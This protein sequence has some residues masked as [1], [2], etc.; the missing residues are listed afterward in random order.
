M[1]KISTL[2]KKDL[3]DLSRVTRE[4]DEENA[5]VFESGIPT[6]K[7]DGT[8]CAIIEG[9]LY[10]RYDLKVGRQ[11]PDGAI[12]CQEADLKTGHHPHWIPVTSNDK[13]HLEAFEMLEPK[14]DGTYE[15]CGPKING[16][17]EKLTEHILIPHGLDV[18]DITDFSF[19][20]L[21]MYLSDSSN[22]IEGIVFHDSNGSGRMCKIR[23][24]DFG[25]ER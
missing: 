3:T 1:K 7:Y 23:K 17:K 22:D 5:W 19:D 12:P 6:R 20:S 24:V 8:S 25:F 18:L 11:L 10:K 2:Y 4:L 14:S 9:Q 15:L 16:N 13:Y 21:R